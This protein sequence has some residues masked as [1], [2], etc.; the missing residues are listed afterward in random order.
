ML[1][2]NPCQKFFGGGFIIKVCENTFFRGPFVTF[3]KGRIWLVFGLCSVCVQ[4]TIPSH[5]VCWWK[6]FGLVFLQPLVKSD[7]SIE[8]LLSCVQCL[9]ATTTNTHPELQTEGYPSVT[10]CYKSSKRQNFPDKR[11]G[12]CVRISPLMSLAALQ[13]FYAKDMRRDHMPTP[14][15][16]MNTVGG[17]W[18]K[19]TLSSF[20]RSVNFITSSYFIPPASEAAAKRDLGLC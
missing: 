11:R 10:L 1:H 8:V 15:I 9:W 3:T 5:S 16:I 14:E 4:T 2:L 18:V 13:S 19:I 20:V 17:G 6:G 12:C 7:D